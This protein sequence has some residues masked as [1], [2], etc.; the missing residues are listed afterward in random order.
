MASFMSRKPCLIHFLQGYPTLFGCR[1]GTPE[2]T[3]TIEYNVSSASGVEQHCVPTGMSGKEVMIEL[4]C[5]GRIGLPRWRSD[6]ES[7][8][9]AGAV[10]DTVLI[11]GVRKIPWRMSWQPTPVFLPGES[12]G[13]RSLAG[14][15]SWGCKEFGHNWS[16]LAWT[17]IEG[18]LGIN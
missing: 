15:S 18:E 2:S 12:H 1:N 4:R 9:S 10:G 14:C 16:H 8:C 7:A 6:K 11:S 5:E 13:Q 17:H 3:I